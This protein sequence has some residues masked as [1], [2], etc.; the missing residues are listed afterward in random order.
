MMLN[1]LENVMPRIT[2]PSG[3]CPS[4]RSVR[5][6]LLDLRFTGDPCILDQ[7]DGTASLRLDNYRLARIPT[8]PFDLPSLNSLFLQLR[9]WQMRQRLYRQLRARVRKPV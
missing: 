4:L 3:S 7:Q 5:P 9:Q 2:R 1:V 6:S 8:S